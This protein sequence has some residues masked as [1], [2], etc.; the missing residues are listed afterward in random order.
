[1]SVFN[2]EILTAKR[3]KGAR[4]ICAWFGV[5]VGC[6]WNALS[7]HERP[8]DLKYPAWVFSGPGNPRG[9]IFDPSTGRKKNV[10][11]TLEM[12]SCYLHDLR[13]AFPLK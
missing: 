3:T 7:C 10:I 1:V 2:D 13:K 4:M 9:E 8:T 6:V 11:S 5:R 12:K